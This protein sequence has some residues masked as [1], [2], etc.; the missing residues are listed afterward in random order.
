MITVKDGS[1]F[2][3]KMWKQ[4][5]TSDPD[6]TKQASSYGS[7]PRR[8]KDFICIKYPGTSSEENL[9]KRGTDEQRIENQS[10]K[11]YS[12]GSKVKKKQNETKYF[13]F[14][15]EIRTHLNVEI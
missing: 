6:N 11:Q 1:T 10:R 12:L 9:G 13:I 15:N 3:D 2:C 14:N 8:T 5:A 7:P 4:T